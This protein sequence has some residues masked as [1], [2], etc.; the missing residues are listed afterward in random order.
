MKTDPFRLLQFA[1][2]VLCIAL[3]CCHKPEP[4]HW[5]TLTWSAPKPSPGV[6]IKSYNLYRSTTS[7]GPFAKLASQLA[8][9]PYDDHLVN[10]GRTYYYVVTA[11]DQLGRESGFSGEI[12]ARIP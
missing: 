7:G 2:I 6:S 8:G 11:V 9:P 3:T 10:S 1:A 5:V 4:H 12:Q